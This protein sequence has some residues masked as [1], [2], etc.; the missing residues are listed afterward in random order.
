MFH[1]L[2]NP[3]KLEALTNF[4]IC[5]AEQNI[6]QTLTSCTQSRHGITLSPEIQKSVLNEVFKRP[7]PNSFF[8]VSDNFGIKFLTRLK[9][10][11]RTESYLGLRT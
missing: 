7:T 5:L 4:Y 2:I 9:I 10:M 6:L 3:I 1:Q 11:F 8:N